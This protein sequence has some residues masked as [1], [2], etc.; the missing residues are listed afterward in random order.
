[1]DG[2]E[3]GA[4]AAAISVDL[5]ARTEHRDAPVGERIGGPAFGNQQRSTRI[6]IEVLGVLGQSADQEDRV[7][8]VKPDG[9]ERAVRV[10]LRIQGQRAEGS[11]RDLSDQRSGALGVGRRRN[12]LVVQQLGCA[13]GRSGVSIFAHGSPIL[14]LSWV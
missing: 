13:S 2:Q 8:I 14:R 6:A 4:S 3:R 12:I 5:R 10:T 11:R 1:M 9:H 7:A